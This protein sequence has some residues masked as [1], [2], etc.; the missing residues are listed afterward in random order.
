MKKGIR[1]AGM[2]AA[3]LVFSFQFL[4]PQWQLGLPDRVYTTAG[5]TTVIQ[6]GLPISVS[7]SAN[8]EGVEGKRTGHHRRPDRGSVS[9]H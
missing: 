4:L 8:R 3:A 6:A 2:I 1:I 7:V 9:A 5:E